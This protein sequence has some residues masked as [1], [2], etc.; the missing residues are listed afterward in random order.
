MDF[1]N[2]TEQI[3]R[4]LKLLGELQ[5]EFNQTNENRILDYIEIVKAGII[6]ILIKMES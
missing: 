5:A 4:S 2:N 3:K 6:D 1:I